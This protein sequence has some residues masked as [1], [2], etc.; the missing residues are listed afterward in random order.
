MTNWPPCT[1]D[2]PPHEVWSGRSACEPTGTKFPELGS[3][4][5]MTA[6]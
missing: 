4:R 3:A 2:L 1:V 5:A 6:S